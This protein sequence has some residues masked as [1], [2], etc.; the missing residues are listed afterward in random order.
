MLSLSPDWKRLAEVRG[1]PAELVVDDRVVA[2]NVSGFAWALDSSRLAFSGPAGVFVVRADGSNVVQIGE[3][4]FEPTWSP[5]GEWVAYQSDA[6]GNLDIHVARSDGGSDVNLSGGDRRHNLGARWSPDSRSL[7][8]VT[9][10]GRRV[11]LEL[12][13]LAGNR[14]TLPFKVGVTNAVVAWFPDGRRIAVGTPYGVFA[15]EVETGAARKWISGMDFDW[16]PDGRRVAFVAGRE[17]RDR[18]GIYVANADGSGIRRITNDCRIIGTDGSDS[19]VGTELA[20]ILLGLNGNDTLTAR[21]PYYMGDTLDGG[22]GDDVLIGDWKLDTLRGGPGADTLRGGPSGDGLYGGPGRDVIDGQGGRD[23]IFAR[24]GERDVVRCGTNQGRGT[25][26]RDTAYVDR[27]DRVA[28][29]CEVVH[30]PRR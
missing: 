17:C 11:W 24:D 27:L 16:S 18:L 29:D 6:A 21:D 1:S 8:F 7:A 20:D 15:L 12:T 23:L 9:S 2:R 28:R 10:N 22:A 3:R 4:G 26:E 14:R 30:R 5:S 25:P 13:D 19:L